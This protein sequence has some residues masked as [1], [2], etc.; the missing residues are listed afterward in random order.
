MDSAIVEEAAEDPSQPRH[1][2][3]KGRIARDLA[4]QP[5]PA[6]AVELADRVV[7]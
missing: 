4:F 6:R 3:R 7:Q 5:F 1:A 2:L